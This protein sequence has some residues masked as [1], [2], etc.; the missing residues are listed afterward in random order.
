MRMTAEDRLRSYS[1]LERWGEAIHGNNALAGGQQVAK[2]EGK[3]GPSLTGLYSAGLLQNLLH[4][5][6]P[7]FNRNAEIFDA[8][9]DSE[10]K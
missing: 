10:N 5:N 4:N 7:R 9:P 3:P 2:V 8:F 6:V 1:E